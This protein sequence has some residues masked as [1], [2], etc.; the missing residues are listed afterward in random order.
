[1]QYFLLNKPFEVLTQFTDE[2]G[3]RTLKDFVPVPHVYPVGRLDYDSEGLVLLTDDKQLQHRLSDPKFKVEK[4]YWAQVEG[5]PSDEALDQLERGVLLQGKKTSPAKARLLE[6][7]T[8]WER[9][10]PIRF[11]ANIPTSWVEIK[12]SQG[13]N[14]Q[15]RKMT[16]A[17]GYPTLR[18][19]RVAIGPLTLGSLAPGEFRALTAEEV[20]Q[21]NGL[22]KPVNTFQRPYKK[23]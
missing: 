11:R 18:L 9:S 5:V 4:T 12:I 23:R 19:V 2:T 3:R 16:A 1:M 8:L 17:V 20:K 10:K 6:E 15:V 22:A 21:L 14:R 13:M 7:V